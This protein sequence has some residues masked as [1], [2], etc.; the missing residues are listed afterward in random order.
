MRRVPDAE[1]DRLDSFHPLCYTER[2]ET[3]IISGDLVVIPPDTTVTVIRRPTKATPDLTTRTQKHNTSVTVIEVV[4]DCVRWVG[5]YGYINSAAITDVWKLEHIEGRVTCYECRKTM[6][7]EQFNTQKNRSLTSTCIQC[8]AEVYRTKH[9]SKNNA[10]RR[11]RRYGVDEATY[12]RMLETQDHRC[13]VCRELVALNVDH[14]HETGKV[15]DLLC[16]PCNLALGYVND[17]PSLLRRLAS[18]VESHS[19]SD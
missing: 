2:M 9:A 14:D 15:R 18:Y 13:F 10:T 5:R 12:A 6:N 8:Q 7:P 19:S 11:L 4:D 16:T 3:D 1:G 17:D